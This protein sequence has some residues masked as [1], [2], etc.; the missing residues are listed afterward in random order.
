MTKIKLYSS[1]QIIFILLLILLLN[2]AVLSSKAQTEF[3]LN[4]ITSIGGSGVGYDVD[5]D[6]NYAYITGNDGYIVVDIQ[7]PTKPKIISD[8]EINGG[9]FGI[10][11]KD[12]IAYVAAAGQGLFITDVSDPANPTLLGHENGGGISNNVYVSGDYAYISNYENGLQIFDVTDLTNP[13]KIGEYSLDG[14]AD[15]VV[16]RDNFAYVANPNSRVNVLNVTIPSAP[17]KVS[18]LS[19]TDG[20]TGISAFEN[21]LFVG[22]YSSNVLVFDISTPSNPILLGLHTDDDEGEAQGVVGN[23]THLYVADNYGVE[24]LNI[25]SL[26][27]IT[28]IAEQRQGVSAAHDIDFKDNFLYIAGG[29]VTGSLVFEVSKSQKSNYLGIYIGVPLTVIVLSV[30]FLLLYKYKIKKKET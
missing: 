24:Y 20:A 5:I 14:R 12:D 13:T 15:G 11:V 23:S 27:T 8:F 9:A 4:K 28:K 10:F 2:Y 16:V 6:C 22:C 26:P 1:K 29:S 25:S 3:Y 17:Q 30:T 7:N 18:T 21:L 19:A